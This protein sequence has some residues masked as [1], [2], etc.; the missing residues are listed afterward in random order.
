V[1]D[2]YWEPRL[3]QLPMPSDA[4]QVEHARELRE[5]LIKEL[6][7]GLSGTEL[8]LLTLSGGV[9]SSSL[10]VLAARQL[11]LPL[12]TLTFVA[13]SGS[14]AR[15]TQLGFV[16]PLL[17]E[18][19]IEE[20]LLL[21]A[22][23]QRLDELFASPFAALC[24][25]P[26]PALRL[27]PALGRRF[28]TLVS[29]HFADE[30][31]GYSQRLQDWVR[32]TSFSEL[33]TR[34]RPQ[35]YGLRD[36]LR[37]GKRRLLNAFGREL[38]PLPAALSEV[39]SP[40]LRAEFLEWRGNTRSRMLAD[41]RP[42]RE[43]AAWVE[44][45]GWIAMHWEHASAASVVP[46]HPFFNRAA[47][48]LG[49]RCHPQELFGPGPKKLLRKALVGFVP[50]R[51]LFRE[52]KGHW[53]RP[54]RVELSAWRGSLAELAE[55][56]APASRDGARELRHPERRQLGQLALF[57]TAWRRER[58]IRRAIMAASG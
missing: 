12:A 10:A 51:Y 20:R 14:Q 32:H 55:V 3:G 6:Q 49:F 11:R 28:A 47:L 33:L 56:V 15:A 24:Y 23:N 38:L 58:E 39:V 48:E 34:R 31:C 30:L 27:L 4:V 22:E 8:N 17:T 19:G 45:D 44:L 36:A 57:E 25:C 50:E 54:P 2:R 52:D 26:H 40:Q 1:L 9:D 18:L 29:G 37:W 16:E 13:P 42:L 43:L 21:D 5:L 46:V 7:D 41:L 35:R 53:R